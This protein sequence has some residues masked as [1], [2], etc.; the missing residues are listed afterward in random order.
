MKKSTIKEAKKNSKIAAKVVQKS[1]PFDSADSPYVRIKKLEAIDCVVMCDGI[2]AKIAKHIGV[3]RWELFGWTVKDSTFNIALEQRREVIIDSVESV[4]MEIISTGNLQAVMYFLDRK[5]KER[6]YNK[7]AKTE[8]KL[9]IDDNTI[10]A[11]DL[12]ATLKQTQKEY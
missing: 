12:A 7:D 8:L 4:L 2:L 3:D 1:Y 11:I 6:G 10:A 5:A 9:T